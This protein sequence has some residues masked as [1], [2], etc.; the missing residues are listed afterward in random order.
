MTVQIGGNKVYDAL[1][2]GGGASGLLAAN[3]LA[4]AGLAAA[5]LEQADRVGKKLL[6]TGNGRCNIT[7]EDWDIR[8]WH[9]H[10][11]DKARA[12]LENCGYQRLTD[13]FTS[14]GLLLRTEDMGRVYPLSGTAASVLDVLRLNAE[15]AGAELRCA[16]RVKSA[17]ADRG[18]WRVETADGAS[19]RSRRLILACGGCAQPVKPAPGTAKVEWDALRMLK[20]AGHAIAATEPALAPLICDTRYLRGLKGVKVKGA[21]SLLHGDRLLAREVGELL[22]TDYGVSGV[23]ALQLSRH[24]CRGCALSIDLAP[25]ISEAQLRALLLER[26]EAI[27]GRPAQ[28][29]LTGIL[30]RLLAQNVFHSAEVDPAKDVDS[31]RMSELNALCRRLKDF[32]IPVN[33]VQGYDMAQ[34]MRG[35]ARLSDF[36][37]RLRSLKVDLPLYALGELLDVDGECGGYNLSWAFASAIAAADGIIGEGGI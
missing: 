16:C 15:C 17:V 25:D 28:Q 32:R 19:L 1:I 14:L 20:S 37:S 26:V 33:G 21:F 3:L 30:H 13:V 10:D 29:L 7:N 24:Y 35:G 4:R 23:A 27:S 31:L 9:S 36:D 6:A 5:V 22:F 8:H 12:V 11:I 18:A 2:I 34:V